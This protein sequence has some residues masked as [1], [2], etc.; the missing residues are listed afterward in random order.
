MQFFTDSKAGDLVSRTTND[1]SAIQTVVTSTLSSL[2]QNVFSIIAALTVMFTQSWQLTLLSL[3]VL[4]A[5]IIPTQRTGHRRRDLQT[6]IQ[7]TLA[8]EV[9]VSR[10]MP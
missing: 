1:V 4:P 7:M 6:Q 8:R 5:F 9:S 10:E 3:L 2:V